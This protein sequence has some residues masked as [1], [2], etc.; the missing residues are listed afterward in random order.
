PRDRLSWV[1][2]SRGKGWRFIGA[3]THC[4]RNRDSP[5]LNAASDRGT[6]VTIRTSPARVVADEHRHQIQAFHRWR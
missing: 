6:P 1:V 4:D 2:C 5:R 3:S